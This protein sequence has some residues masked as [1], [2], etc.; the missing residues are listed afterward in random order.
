MAFYS[1]EDIGSRHSPASA[2][3]EMGSKSIKSI[4]KSIKNHKRHSL[5]QM[6]TE[7]KH[8]NAAIQI[9][10]NEWQI[11]VCSSPEQEAFIRV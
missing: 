6:N 3:I 10:E 8:V 1:S 7:I 5:A 2:S 11:N 4:R 9:H